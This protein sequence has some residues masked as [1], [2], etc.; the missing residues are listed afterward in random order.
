MGGHIV[1]LVVPE[2]AGVIPAEA[3]AMYPDLMFVARGI[4]LQSR[5]LIGERP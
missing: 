3:T 4:G 5:P 2:A 1:G